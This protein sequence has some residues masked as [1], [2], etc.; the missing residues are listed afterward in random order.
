LQLASDVQD[1]LLGFTQVSFLLCFVGEKE[2]EGDFD[3]A[4][5]GAEDVLGGDVYLFWGKRFAYHFLE[6][7]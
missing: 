4:K 2:P 3:L 7:G 6:G 5:F 1:L